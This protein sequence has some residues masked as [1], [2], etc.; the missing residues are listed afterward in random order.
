M[1]TR[2][3]VRLAEKVGFSTK[4]SSS[5]STSVAK[6]ETVCLMIHSL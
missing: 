6:S 4:A 2:R 3:L 1:R 5:V